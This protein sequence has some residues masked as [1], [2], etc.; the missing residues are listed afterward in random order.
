MKIILVVITGFVI[1]C[2]I[3]KKNRDQI[4]VPND[5][6]RRILTTTFNDLYKSDSFDK[7][8]IEIQGYF[9]YSFEDHALYP[10]KSSDTKK[11]V[12]IELSD[13]LLSDRKLL[14]KFEGKKVSIVGNYDS[15]NK[16]HLDSYLATIAE[17][18]CIKMTD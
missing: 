5:Q 9:S 7:N 18:Y 16:G 6:N 15:K 14:S 13:K 4:C 3:P 10:D 17:V 11:A 12:W 8:D 1:S 2:S